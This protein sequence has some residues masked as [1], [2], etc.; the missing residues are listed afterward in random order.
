MQVNCSMIF[1]TNPTDRGMCCTFNALAAEK[2]YRESQFSR[3]VNSLQRQNVFDSFEYPSSLPTGFDSG[4]EPSPETG[5]IK[6][7]IVKLKSKRT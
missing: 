4:E 3:S 5:I 2:I 6:E 1:M 7:I